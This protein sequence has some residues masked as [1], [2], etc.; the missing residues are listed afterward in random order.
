MLALLLV[1]AAAALL[2]AGVSVVAPL[3]PGIGW[4]IGIDRR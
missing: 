4:T 2:P 1:L 3:M